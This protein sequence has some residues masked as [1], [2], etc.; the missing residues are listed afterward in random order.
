LRNVTVIDG[1]GKAAQP[2]MTV[3]IVGNRIQSVQ[4]ANGASLG[5]DVQVEDVGGRYLIPGLWEMHSHPDPK[6]PTPAE[7][8]RR[9]AK[10]PRSSSRPALLTGPTTVQ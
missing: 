3:V 6:S 5:P 8:P 10:G 9:K 4:P 1:T 2:G 7:E